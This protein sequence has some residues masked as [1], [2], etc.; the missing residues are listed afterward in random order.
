MTQ[1]HSS[2]YRFGLAVLLSGTAPF[3]AWAQQ[4]PLAV[5]D[6]FRLEALGNV[7]VSPDGRDVAVVVQR[8]WTDPRTFRPYDLFG[9]DHADLWLLPARGGPARNLTH[10]ARDGSGYWN[11]VWSPGG[12]SVALLSTRGGDNVRLYV[13]DRGSGRLRRLTE[14]GVDL[15]A[16]TNAGGDW[17]PQP[18][19][20]VDST[21]LLV[22]VLPQG[23]QPAE[24]R[25]RRQA[26]RSATAA[27]AEA[28]RGQV[29]TA[30]VLE[31]GVSPAQSPAELLLVDAATGRSRMLVSGAIRHVLLAPDRRHVAVVVQDPAVPPAAGRPLSPVTSAPSNSPSSRCMAGVRR[32]GLRVC[33]IQPSVSERTHTAGRP[34]ARSYRQV[35]WPFPRSPGLRQGIC[36]LWRSRPPVG[37][38][39]T[40]LTRLI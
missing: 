24:Y 21:H 23:E 28:A 26:Q 15:R 34:R 3:A 36:S 40:R 2:V 11:P 27:W 17:P 25:A 6:L 5:D 9:N 30:S 20:W 16:G 7:A 31:S 8:A 1:G 18:V 4:R 37:P 14:R 12:R 39:G 35:T 29:P 38:T 32:V 33:T 19:E 10:G 13:W 22:T